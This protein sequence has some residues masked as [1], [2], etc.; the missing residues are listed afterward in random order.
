MKAIVIARV[1]D[2]S[3]ED[4]LSLDAQKR[5]LNTYMN[6]HDLQLIHEP[7]ELVESST[8]GERKK[9]MSIINNALE[10]CENE[11][12][13]V[14]TDR[15]DRFQ[16]G[17]KEQVI[18]LD[19][20]KNDRL[21]LHFLSEN[22]IIH[23][24]SKSNVYLQWNM[25]I[26]GAQM[27][28]MNISDNVNR[29]IE[30]NLEQGRPISKLPVGYLN[31]RVIVGG[32][33][34]GTGKIDKKKAHLV[35]EAFE[36]YATGTYS[37]KK[38]A[39]LMREKGLTTTGK[40]KIERPI[41]TTH[42][43]RMLKDPI[44]YGIYEAKGKRIVHDFGKIISKELFD[45][46]QTV[47]QR[48]SRYAE[49][50]ADNEYIFKGLLRC[51]KCGK[52]FSTYT[53]KGHNYAKC[54]T[55]KDECDNMNVA[56]RIL[57]EQLKEVFESMIVPSEVM[58]E[59]VEDMQKLRDEKRKFE[60]EQ[61]GAIAKRLREIES[62]LNVLIDMRLK[63]SI[64][65]DEYDKKAIELKDEKENLLGI[66][67]RNSNN[68]RQAK[69]TALDLL[70]ITNRAWDIFES[71]SIDRKRQLLGMLSSNLTVYDKN[72]CVYLNNP[73]QAIADLN[74]TQEWGGRWDLNPRHAA[75]QAAALPT[76]L[77]PP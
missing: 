33:D 75:P 37:F 36:L 59:L 63:Q 1:S 7:Y 60:R 38:L 71:S 50:Y 9:F 42:I 13:A 69:K 44:Y 22:L 39:K 5:R 19:L 15:V 54:N 66:Q 20:I 65:Q 53:Q 61:E 57:L 70:S 29:V 52:M 26:M 21:V 2:E 14:V 49:R 12:L 74:K 6:E 67:G 3:Q 24:K 68:T 55:P 48:K 17:F 58:Q 32:K 73:F 77:R 76:E 34:R 64:T 72:L 45:Q 23:S 25:H 46:C 43:E 4:G 51:D 11:P 16:R 30:E 35:K 8:R 40:H 47:K 31:D 27:Y 28:V 41:S 62:M 18:F 10:E 56:E